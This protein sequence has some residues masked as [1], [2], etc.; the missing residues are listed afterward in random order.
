MIAEVNLVAS[1]VKSSDTVERV[2]MTLVIS[3]TAVVVLGDSELMDVN[4]LTV[5]NKSSVVIE[6][7]ETGRVELVKVVSCSSVVQMVTR[8][9]VDDLTVGVGSLVVVSE[10]ADDVSG[11]K[12]VNVEK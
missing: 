3:G 6:V 9:E 11:T 2:V 12:E 8:S 5:V 4:S 7:V 10:T 1:V